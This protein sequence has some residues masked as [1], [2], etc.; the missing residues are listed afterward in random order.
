MGEATAPKAP[1]EKGVSA[2][3][4]GMDKAPLQGL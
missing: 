3:L 1:A 4:Q 2:S